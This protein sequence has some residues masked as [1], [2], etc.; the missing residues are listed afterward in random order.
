MNSTCMVKLSDG[1]RNPEWDNFVWETP[2]GHYSQTSQWG[3]VKALQ[4]WQVLC[5]QLKMLG[6][7]IAGAQILVRSLPAMGSIAY[8][9][10]GPLLRVYE[11]ELIECCIREIQNICYRH[12]IQYLAVQPP[13]HEVAELLLEMGFQSS[14]QGDIEKPAT[15]VFD[16]TPSSEDILLGQIKPRKRTDIRRSQKSGV[17]YYQ[18]SKPDLAI[19]YRLYQL[20]GERKQF[21]LESL[22]FFEKMW[23]IFEPR[24]QLALFL[25]EY[26]GEPLSALLVLGY[27]DT[28]YY[29]R[30]GW[31]GKHAN[32]HPNEG[33]FWQGILWAKAHGYRWFD[34]G[35]IDTNVARAFLHGQRLPDHMR[36]TYTEYKLRY[37]NQIEFHPEVYEYICNPFLRRLYPVLFRYAAPIL[38]FIYR[39]SRRR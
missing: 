2:D 22:A 17:N 31:S 27:K 29:Y 24:N 23:E 8:I 9:S 21:E 16:L 3:Q 12:H 5:M 1:L 32:M 28:A 36:N 30:I 25:A 18:G 14:N 19:L 35:G 15:I 26:E 4:G 11:R 6:E 33:V 7:T 34:F 37:S 39:L 38:L 20:T 10:K 13:A